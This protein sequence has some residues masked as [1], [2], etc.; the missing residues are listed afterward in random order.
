[1]S[2]ATAGA[3]LIAFISVFLTFGLSAQTFPAKSVRL[4]VG[5]ATGGGTDTIAR[6]ISKKLADAWPHALVVENRP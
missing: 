6:V 5:F 1:M 3:T 2:Q 4:V